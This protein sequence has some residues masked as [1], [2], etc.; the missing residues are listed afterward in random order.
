MFGNKDNIDKC[1]SVQRRLP[2]EGC[3]TTEVV[4]FTC[5]NYPTHKRKK[6]ADDTPENQNNNDNN[7]NI[8]HFRVMPK[9]IMKKIHWLMN[10]SE[11]VLIGKF[12]N[13][14]ITAIGERKRERDGKRYE[15]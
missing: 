11:I 7:N 10:P 6:M 4:T 8:C 2:S 3:N 12:Y 1:L 13:Q 15:I 5:M 14:I 9:N